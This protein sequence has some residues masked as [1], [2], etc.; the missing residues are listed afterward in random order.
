MDTRA[1]EPLC[2]EAG[3]MLQ[4]EPVD[5]YRNPAT[6]PHRPRMAKPCCADQRNIDLDEFV[7]RVQGFRLELLQIDQVAFR[8]DGV[9]ADV[10]DVLIGTARFRRALVQTWKSP[11]Q[12]IA[13]AARTSRAP[14]LWQGTYFG[15]SD[16][17]IAGAETEIELVSRPGF[18]VATVS[19]PDHEFQRAAE[20]RGC[21]SIIDK[22]KC[23]LVRLPKADA[24]HE[25]RTT[26][27][28]L[29]SDILANPADARDPKCD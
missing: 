2:P 19:V 16:L 5:R 4:R 24:A 15:P 27:H 10:G 3:T 1:I 11:T 28:S 13:I 17:L 18:G 21:G 8:A 7:S 23:I 29:I 20:P 22:T 14:A 26:I 25:L 6:L 9:Q 12:S